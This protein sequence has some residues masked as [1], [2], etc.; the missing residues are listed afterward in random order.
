MTFEEFKNNLPNKVKVYDVGMD[1][2]RVVTLTEDNRYITGN[3]GTSSRKVFNYWNLENVYKYAI[4][5]NGKNSLY[6]DLIETRTVGKTY[7]KA[8]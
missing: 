3:V 5:W 8:T 1:K 7:T 4:T 2:V 6:I